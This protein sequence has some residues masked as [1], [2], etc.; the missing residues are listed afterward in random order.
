MCNTIHVAG[1]MFTP[2]TVANRLVAPRISP[3]H[4]PQALAEGIELARKNPDGA[5]V[6]VLLTDACRW[7]FFS[8][9]VVRKGSAASRKAGGAGGSAGGAGGL[10]F[11]F[12]RSE[13]TF[14]L[15]DCAHVTADVLGIHANASA[16]VEASGQGTAVAS[17][18]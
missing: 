1:M 3:P 4:T 17:G 14:C 6:R 11:S 16:A 2:Q 12:S 13:E 9:R 18:G 7:Y 5:S 8:L 10:E 15:F